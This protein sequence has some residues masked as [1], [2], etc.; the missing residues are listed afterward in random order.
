[1][2]YD[3]KVMWYYYNIQRMRYLEL[4]KECCQYNECW[5]S[6]SLMTWCIRYEY[7]S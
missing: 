5:Y 6:C 7:V 2:G 3:L 1:M 4:N